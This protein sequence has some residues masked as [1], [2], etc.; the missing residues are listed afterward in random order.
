MTSALAG[1]P[2]LAIHHSIRFV[3]DSFDRFT[4][5]WTRSTNLLPEGLKRLRCGE[6]LVSHHGRNGS[7]GSSAISPF[8]IRHLYFDGAK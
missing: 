4:W 6:L 5:K 7:G 2:Y 1:Q 3:F 8:R